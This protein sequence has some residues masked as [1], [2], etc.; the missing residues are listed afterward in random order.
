MN[1]V[2]I[3]GIGA[4]TPAGLGPDRLSEQVFSGRSCVRRIDRFDAG[5]YQ[6]QVAGQA[7]DFLAAD[8]LPPRFLKRT[9][10]FTHLATVAAGAAIDSAQLRIGLGG[11]P[12]ERVGVMVGNVLGGWEF[13][14]RE[15]RDLWTSGPREV[16]P[17]QATAWFPAAPQGNICIRYGIH[18][19]SRT[20]VCDRA[21]GAV[22]V[23]HAAETVMRGQA[24]VVIAGG[25]EQPLSPYAWLCCETGGF[26]ARSGSREPGA[27]YRPFDRGHSGTVVGE[28][29]VF[30]VLEHPEHAAQRG[31]PVL[32]ELRGWSMSTDGYQPYYTVE[33]RGDTLAR[34][35]GSALRAAS[36]EAADLGGVLADGSGVPR[37]DAA[38]VAAI[39]AAL[40]G[41]HG[42]VPVTATKAAVGHLLGAG[43]VADLA[44]AVAALARGALPPTANL[45]TPAPGFDLDFVRDEPR[46]VRD[47]APLLSVSRGLGGVN[48]CLV[49]GPAGDP[50]RRP[51]ST[52][53]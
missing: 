24:D 44:V 7:D 25:T 38:E 49:V 15:L 10:R 34:T 2:A 1:P 22:A 23:L 28:G 35:I 53:N 29:S 32:A 33:P 4:I 42:T 45:G 43:P 3:T 18:G 39:R 21:S 20:F 40:N 47:G 19:R 17:Y 26:L 37:E 36:C 50:D 5:P 30:L 16:S 52:G 14:E 9:D 46:A 11:V 6:C 41:S 8:W 12:A 31:V 48:V 13:A 27:T 51:D